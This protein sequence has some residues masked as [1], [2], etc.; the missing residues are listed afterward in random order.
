MSDAPDKLDELLGRKPSRPADRALLRL[1]ASEAEQHL[2]PVEVLARGISAR[3]LTG[4]DPTNTLADALASCRDAGIKYGANQL[5]RE[6]EALIALFGEEAARGILKEKYRFAIDARDA[7]RKEVKERDREL[8]VINTRII[9][10][11]AIEEIITNGGFRYRP[12]PFIAGNVRLR[13][14]EVIEQI[15]TPFRDLLT[16]VGKTEP[17]PK[18]HFLSLHRLIMGAAKF[19][20]RSLLAEDLAPNAAFSREL[21]AE[22][23]LHLPFPQCWF[24]WDIEPGHTIAGIGCDDT[25]TGR[26]LFSSLVRVQ[27]NGWSNWD[28]IERALPDHNDALTEH[29]EMVCRAA[30]VILN[31]R[32]AEKTE[33][34][35]SAQIN[36]QRERGAAP[37]LFS[38]TVV[39]IRG[40]VLGRSGEITGRTHRSPRMHW[41]RGHLRHFRNAEGEV[42]RITPIAPMLIG[43]DKLGKIEHDY[44]V[45]SR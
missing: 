9:H 28:Y 26:I 12:R 22:G 37:P 7:A 42:Y 32:S 29:V 34:H 44:M 16:S 39:E 13:A 17:R 45:S 24:E 4:N 30:L 3:I 40:I 2:N 15:N 38:H 11:R 33:I 19:D 43:S 27:G 41:R 20:I 10:L 25:E 18:E 5:R 14:H 35:P 36:R 1:P 8:T 31:S 21:E 6:F 23:L